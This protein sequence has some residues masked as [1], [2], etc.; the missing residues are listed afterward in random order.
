MLVPLEWIK[1]YIDIEMSVE[2]VENTLTMLGLEV[3]GIEKAGE[4]HLLDVNVTPNRPDCL[5][6]IGIARELSAATGLPVKL[7]DY[8]IEKEKPSDFKI[9]ILDEQLCQ[10]YAGRVVRG[11]TMGESPGWMRER[12]EKCGIR[13][14]NNIVDISNYALLEFGHPLHAFDLGT[15]KGNTI[16][17]KTAGAGTKMTTLDGEERELPGDALL[18]WDGERPVAVAGVMGG[19]E[20]EVTEKT[21]DIL[22]ESAY[23]D[24]GSVRRTSKAL[25]LSTESSYR[26]ERG[27]DIEGL[28]TALDRAAHLVLEMAGGEAESKVDVY[29]VKFS[30][31]E[32]SIKHE[33]VN[34]V[35]GTKLSG[36][37]IVT[38]L[39]K[40]NLDV[41]KDENSFTVKPPPSR[42]DITMDAD[43]IEE[44]ARLYGYG[45]IPTKAPEAEISSSDISTIR[46][47]ISSV[48]EMVR[49]GG[50]NEAI[51]Y[52]FM[53]PGQ[54]DL[55]KIPD[56]DPR[57]RCVE[58][59]NPLRQEEAFLRTTLVPS[60]LEMFTHNFFRGVK[61]IRLFEVSRVFESTDELLPHESLRLGGVYSTENTHT[62][63]KETAEGFYVVKG[64]I[65][66]L[67]ESLRIKDCSFSPSSE[68][69]L[70]PGKSADISVSGKKAGFMG[71][72][73][74][75]IIEALDIKS[76]PEALIFELDMESIIS[77]T[78][79]TVDEGV[80]ASEI[81]GAIHSYPSESIEEVLVFD[82]YRGGNLPKG[83]KS[84]AFSI[85][86]RSEERTL[87][88]DEVDEIHNGILE[89]LRE[90]TGAEI[91]G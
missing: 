71:V 79:E 82:S 21:T 42:P 43:I 26:F 35:L 16:R 9:E 58:I 14:I 41:K 23:F 8:G 66:A 48:K 51:S 20:T 50:F 45:R 15:L 69:F 6:I 13:S 80:M 4:D 3:E 85:R 65:E 62:L 28:E 38:L 19:A 12:L 81:M 5:S 11:I 44:I 76:R 39:E 89:H 47:L 31:H 77:Y 67:L 7:P 40:L 55:L 52:S 37:E 1:E 63:W 84:L 54:L 83:K 68:P 70:H 72:V 2:E 17:V 27:A 18:I 49:K 32:I 46:S 64:L 29:P 86:Y 22:I 88:D 57:R 30:S 10:R 34:R 24:P 73:S 61:D 25:G 36:D 60:L 75:E 90:K 91:R 59:K 56:D 53:N 33:K 78:Q 87:T 74:P